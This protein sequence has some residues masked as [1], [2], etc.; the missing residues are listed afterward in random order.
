MIPEMKGFT[1][2]EID[3]CFERHVPTRKFKDYHPLSALRAAEVV[4]GEKAGT[5]V[6]VQENA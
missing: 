3:E 1:L 5:S 6:E 4:E 2:E